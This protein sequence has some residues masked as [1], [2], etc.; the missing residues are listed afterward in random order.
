MCRSADCHQRHGCSGADG[1][2]AAGV[3][4]KK[5]GALSDHRDLDSRPSW[6]TEDHDVRQLVVESPAFGADRG[7][8]Q[9]ASLVA[10]SYR[11]FEIGLV[12]VLIVANQVDAVTHRPFERRR[13]HGV[14]VANQHVD[15]DSECLGPVEPRVGRNHIGLVGN[16]R[17]QRSNVR[18]FA[19]GNDQGSPRMSRR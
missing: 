17:F 1:Q 10:M 2:R 3:D 15:L 4:R 16:V 7:Y 18:Y 8:R 9:D 13:S 14:E 12:L 6:G 19:A 5:P 11:Q